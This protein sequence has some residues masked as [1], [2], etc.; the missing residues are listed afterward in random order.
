MP[1]GTDYTESQLNPDRVSDGR[2]FACP[3]NCDLDCCAWKPSCYIAGFGGWN[4]NENFEFGDSVT[5]GTDFNSGSLDDGGLVGFVI[6]KQVH[7]VVRYEVEA[8]YR[9]NDVQDWRVQQ[10]ASGVLT[11]NVL[12]AAVG[13]LETYSM[14]ANF[15]LDFAPRQ[16]GCSQ[17]YVGVGFGGASTRG[18]FVTATNTYLV[19]DSSV[20]WQF[21]GGC[22]RAVSR[23][24]DAFLEYR[25]LGVSRIV[26]FDSTNATSLGDFELGN[27]SFQAGLRFRF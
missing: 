13:K 16:T 4:F 12:Q 18:E 15:M 22:N 19:D 23:R 5:D 14:M 6:G 26:V 8:T 17:L 11:S 1:I 3:D 24:V 9:N 21:I 7:P 25:F 27:S 20:A 2:T 10:F